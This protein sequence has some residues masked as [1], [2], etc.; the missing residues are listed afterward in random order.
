MESKHQV[1]VD[2][3]F[4]KSNITS[5]WKRKI[6]IKLFIQSAFAD[7]SRLMGII[8]IHL[9][10]YFLEC[11]HDESKVMLALAGVICKWQRLQ[12]VID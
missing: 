5:D 11:G 7:G 6:E 3:F 9:M 10:N 1:S 4:S 8:C 12:G 2:H